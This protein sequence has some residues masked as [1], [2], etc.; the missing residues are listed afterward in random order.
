MPIRAWMLCGSSFRTWSNC[1]FA[2]C[3]PSELRVAGAEHEQGLGHPRVLAERRLEGLGG[4]P[5]TVLDHQLA[6]LLDRREDLELVLG[7][8]Q[9]SVTSRRLG[10]AG[11]PT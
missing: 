5:G 8:G 1:A 7:I 6:G 11:A 4:R 3:G 10:G 2:S 9:R